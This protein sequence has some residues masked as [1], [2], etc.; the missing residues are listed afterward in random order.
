MGGVLARGGIFSLLFIYLIPSFAYHPAVLKGSSWTESS[1]SIA[2]A[3]SLA[4]VAETPSS[5]YPTILFSEG[6]GFDFGAPSRMIPFTIA[7]Y[8]SAMCSALP[9]TPE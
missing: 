3:A 1:S 4:R 8:S 2:I 6:F 7:S 5:E 9:V